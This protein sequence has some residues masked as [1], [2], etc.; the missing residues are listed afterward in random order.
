[1]TKALVPGSYVEDGKDA[2]GGPL[3][4]KVPHTRKWMEANYEM[5]DFCPPR[6]G[7]VNVNGVG[8]YLVAH[9]HVRIPSII[10]DV[11]LQSIASD[12]DRPKP[13]TAEEDDAIV[14]AAI[15]KPGSCQFSRLAVVGVGLFKPDHISNEQWAKS[16]NA[17]LDQREV[18]RLLAERESEQPKTALG[19][20]LSRLAKR[21]G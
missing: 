1:M 3:L 5:V 18:S 12:A 4:K 16:P 21:V 2:G 19:T 17:S 9:Q 8:Y 6:T 15:K 20:M 11:L 14:R 10:R 7:P 13:W